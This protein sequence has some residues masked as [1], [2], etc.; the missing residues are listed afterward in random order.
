MTSITMFYEHQHRLAVNDILLLGKQ[1]TDT[2]RALKCNNDGN[3]HWLLTLLYSKI[4]ILN[5]CK[6]NLN[7]NF[8]TEVPKFE[9]CLTSPFTANL[10]TPLDKEM[11]LLQFTIESFPINKLCNRVHSILNYLYSR[12]RQIRFF[13]SPFEEVRSNLRTSSIQV[14]RLKVRAPWSTS[15]SR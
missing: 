13:E 6:S 11:V 12:K 10:Y 5:V 9:L 14:A 4:R 2:L 7:L 8:K 15:Y 3:G 1:T